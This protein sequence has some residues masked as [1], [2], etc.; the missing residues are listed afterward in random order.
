MF[1]LKS[2]RE[3]IHGMS[4]LLN[5]AALVSD[6][7]ILNKDGSFSAGF[8]YQGI[9]VSSSSN[10]DRNDICMRVNN[11]LREL[12]SG[13][14][15]QVD[16]IR[17]KSEAY[18][19]KNSSYF[20]HP[21]LQLIDDSRRLYFESQG[22]KFT[23]TYI[24][25]VTYM[26]PSRRA[27]KLADLVFE[28][29][30]KSKQINFAQR[31]L[32][33]FNSAV[34]TLATRLE[35]ACHIERLRAY[36][37][38]TCQVWCD[39]FL[40]YLSYTVT[41]N[42]HPIALPPCPM[43]LDSFIG[44]VDF[45]PGFTPRVDKEFISVITIDGFPSVAHPQY[46]AAL[47]DLSIPYRWST[48]FIFFDD[49]EAQK[50]LKTE[51]KKWEQ[52]VISFKDKL[53][54][55]ADPK[56]DQ[57]AASMVAQYQLAETAINKGESAYGQYSSTII[58]RHT[59][60]DELNEQT[61]YVDKCIR[62]IS[63]MHCRVE[64][65]NA[66]DAFIGTLPSDS[67]ANI[68]KPLLSVDNLVHLMPLNF[69]W[70]GNEFCPCPFYPSKSPPLLV[71]SAQGS[72]VFRL[73]LHVDDLGHTLIFGPTGAG[74]STLLATLA[75]QMNRY[76]N[77][78]IYAF[79]V[80]M[81]MYALS[82]CGGRHYD[83]GND[84]S[85]FAPLSNLDTDFSWCNNFIE[86]LLVLQGL[87]IKPT[88]RTAIYNALMA[89]KD[90]NIK[91]LSEFRTQCQNEDVK[92]HI[93]Y[94]TIN[95]NGG[96][97]LDGE[98]DEFSLS[99]LSVFEIKSL[100]D[101]GDTDCAP[102][103]SYIFRQIELR[104]KGDPAF[105]LIDEGWISL[106]NEKFKNMLKDWLLTLRKLNCVVIFSTQLLSAAIESGI[107]DVL[108]ESCPT[109]IFLPN[110]EA[111]N[112]KHTYKTFGL[113]NAQIKLIK[114]GTKKRDYYVVQG[115]SSRLI[116]LSLDDIAI[117]VVGSSDKKSLLRIKELVKE[118]NENWYLYWLKEKG[119]DFA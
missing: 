72:S 28:K 36:F 11:A 46:L 4:D 111:L 43:A 39:S 118:H 34:D 47:D 61:E 112:I 64:T 2:F 87:V 86:Q 41:G 29:G 1:K 96:D 3:G 80:G 45:L 8:L 105:I 94:Y 13:W 73:N 110:S 84:T 103:L 65:V 113:S 83:I 31:N 97:L 82:Q 109:K 78:A 54:N 108:M 20:T 15:V 74:K 55:V 44:S 52:K 63:G 18:V 106:K 57:A 88:H 12:G 98:S 69:I 115:S 100:M 9:D 70:T 101:R 76:E 48:R 93:E 25:I 5:W 62:Y 6:G 50:L 49:F 24:L 10:T 38:D 26:P 53:L 56:I 17:T 71:A 23:S 77:A 90:S 7:T 14:M 95:G 91:T 119:L 42:W 27:S 66:T 92:S 60:I 33:R 107:L 58:L 114:E 40:S 32:D 21:L 16:A 117:S 75:A 79:D 89:M 85:Q 19:D 22:N 102:V 35:S 67:V 116:D 68:R 37:D 59:D 104:L 51:R 81:S 30:E 99:S